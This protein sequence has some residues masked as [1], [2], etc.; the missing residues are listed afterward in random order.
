MLSNNRNVLPFRPID[1]AAATADPFPRQSPLYFPVSARAV[2]VADANGLPT[3]SEAYQAIVRDDNGSVLGIHTRAYKL[4]P[5]EPLYRGFDEALRRSGIDLSGLI[6]EDHVNYGGKRVIRDYRF[7]TVTTEPCVGDIVQLKVSVINSFDSGNAFC[8]QVGG[9]RLWCLNGAVSNH[10]MSSIYGRHT[11]GFDNARALEK[12]NQALEH[13]L[14]NAAAWSDWAD[15]EIN[16]TVATIAFEAFPDLNDTLLQRLQDAWTT[17]SSHAGKTVWALYNAL[18]RWS[19]HT[20]VR[21]SSEDNR[22]SI[23]LD[24][25]RRVRQFMRSRAFKKLA[26]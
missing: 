25:E 16:D 12:I 22:A 10:G 3:R 24:R 5:N 9:L 2:S 23:V 20:P 17:E 18:T 13:Y 15:R 14:L 8:A 7:P 26:A 21:Q 6:V 1:F 19:T 11:A 4:V